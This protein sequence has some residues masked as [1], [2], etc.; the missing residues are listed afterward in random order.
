[1]RERV[2]WTCESSDAASSSERQGRQ[3]ST[4]GRPFTAEGL[5]RVKESNPRM[6]L[7]KPACFLRDQELG[8]KTRAYPCQCDQRDALLGGAAFGPSSLPEYPVR[9]PGIFSGST[10]DRWRQD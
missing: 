4:R 2:Q 9:C 6:Q 7:G 5:E 3:C 1:V 8:C 10:L